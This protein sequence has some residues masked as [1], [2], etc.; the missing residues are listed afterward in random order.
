[1]CEIV[2]QNFLMLANKLKAK[3]LLN[4]KE[5]RLCVLVLIG[6]FSS[7]QMADILCYGEKSIRSIKRNTAVKLGTN[8]SNLRDFLLQMAAEDT[9]Y[10]A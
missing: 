5:I 6:N 3:H 9:N 7:K 8:S 10:R 4:D 1:M 2:N